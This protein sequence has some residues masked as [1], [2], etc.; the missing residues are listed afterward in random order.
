MKVGKQEIIYHITKR[1]WRNLKYIL[2]SEIIQSQKATQCMNL[3][4][5]HSRKKQN[6]LDGKPN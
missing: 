5:R 3:I 2:L 6:C 1:T 4:A